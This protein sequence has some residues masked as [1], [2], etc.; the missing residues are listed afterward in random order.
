MSSFSIGSHPPIPGRRVA[1]SPGA[2]ASRGRSLALLPAVPESRDRGVAPSP[3]G[4]RVPSPERRAQISAFSLARRHE[5]RDPERPPRPRRPRAVGGLLCPRRR[6]P[7]AVTGASR[8]RPRQPRA[9]PGRSRPRPG[10]PMRRVRGSLGPH[11][12][13]R[14]PSWT[15]CSTAIAVRIS[16][17]GEENRC[18]ARWG[19]LRREE[20][21]DRGSRE[22]R[23]WG[24]SMRPRMLAGLGRCSMAVN[25]VPGVAPR[26]SFR[27]GRGAERRGGAT[28]AGRRGTLRARRSVATTALRR[29]HM[30]TTTTARKRE[31]LRRLHRWHCR[32]PRR[33]L[34]YL[35][36]AHPASARCSRS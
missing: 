25:G 12:L 22:D 4:T 26:R 20:L 14:V 32:A 23:C 30:T 36:P 13:V 18:R 16:R 5:S 1:R 7:R 2:P 29:S 21:E 6:R 10:S 9:V 27:R 3:T 35:R 11:V 31:T 34:P 17:D 15:T 8:P 24:R 19:G 28:P 33:G